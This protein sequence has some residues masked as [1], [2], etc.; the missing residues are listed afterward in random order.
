MERTLI[1]TLLQKSIEELAMMTDGFMEMTEYPAPMLRLARHKAEDVLEYLGQLEETAGCGLRATSEDAAT[2]PAISNEVEHEV[3]HKLNFQQ[4]IEP[5]A[6]LSPEGQNDEEASNHELQAINEDAAASPVI[7]NEMTNFQQ[8]TEPDVEISPDGRD[9]E[10][11]ASHELQATSEEEVLEEAVT[12]E[13]TSSP[14]QPPAAPHTDNTIADAHSMKKV[15]DIRQA[16]SIGDQFRFQRELFASNGE[17]MHKTIAKLNQMGSLDEA[18]KYLQAKF[19][20]NAEDEIVE[21]FLQ[22]IRRR[23]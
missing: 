16:I 20:W 19:S 14:V 6:G 11:A 4:D 18:M 9:D 13:E 8:D 12:I 22:I 2:P 17:L 3:E 7:S 23:W 1:V 10:E 5:D 21:H 15:D